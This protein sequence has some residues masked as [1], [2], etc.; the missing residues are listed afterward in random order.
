MPPVLADLS[1][2]IPSYN[3]RDVLRECLGILERVAAEAEVIVVDGGS[4]DGSPAMVRESFGRV[5]LLEV[6]NH[7]WAHA[8]NRGLEVARGRYLLMM[9][10]DLFVTREALEA[11]VSRLAEDPGLGAVGPVLLNKD[12]SRQWGFGA[13]Y[14]PHWTA[15]N[16]AVRINLLHFA[17]CMTRRDVVE[18]VGAM[19]ENFFF[20]NEEFDWCWR[21]G[22]AGYRLELRPERVVHVEGGSTPDNPDFL[23]EAQRGSLYLMHKHFPALVAQ[24]FRRLLQLEGWLLSSLDPDHRRRPMWARLESLARRGAYTESPF[25]LSGR[26]DTPTTPGAVGRR[27]RPVAAATD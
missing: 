27:R 13:L 25:P 19:D 22:R 5:R 2:V 1:I 10:S 21:V 7:G 23:F 4:S 18:R 24:P 6:S 8:T 20:Y 26:G 11:M 3:G 9:N 17:C 14:W 15:M 16:R 12:G